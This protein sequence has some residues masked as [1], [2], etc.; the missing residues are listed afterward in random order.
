MKNNKEIKIPASVLLDGEYGISDV[1]IG[2]P[3]TIS[4]DGLN[5]IHEIE[6]NGTELTQLRNSANSVKNSIRD[7]F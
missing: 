6:L 7:C 5:Q 1:C 3:T 2:V 4:K